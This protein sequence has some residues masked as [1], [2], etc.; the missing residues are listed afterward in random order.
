MFHL[1]RAEGCG[2]QDTPK[3]DELLQ[4]ALIGFPSLLLPLMD[5]CGV[6]VDSGVKTHP[7]Y[8]SCDL[9]RDPTALRVLIKLYIERSHSL[10][11]E[12]EVISWLE[13]NCR[14]VVA[15]VD[16]KDPLV[17]TC[18]EQRGRRYLG[19]PTN[20]YRHVVVSEFEHAV[21]VLPKE[22]TSRPITMYDPLPPED[23]TAGY[24][25]PE[26]VQPVSS[27][28]ESLISLFLRSLLPSFNL[29]APGANPQQARRQQPQAGGGGAEGGGTL[30][31][32]SPAL[33]LQLALEQLTQSL[34]DLVAQLRAPLGEGEGQGSGEE[35]SSEDGE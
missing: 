29:Q 32:Q 3:A 17:E 30:G 9:D 12:P 10:W 34:H 2:L 6:V 1:A 8:S 16:S 22:V 13:C 26:R 27:A 25:R 15:R 5:K 28:N 35:G 18:T 31:T 14:R 4:Q 7:F 24:S 33:N 21:A 11:K 23:S 19:T 20:V